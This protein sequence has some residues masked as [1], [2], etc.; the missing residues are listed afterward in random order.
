MCL[1]EDVV[2]D[3]GAKVLVAGGTAGVASLRKD[4]GLSHAG[5]SH[6]ELALAAP[7]LAR[8]EPNSG[9][10]GTSVRI[11]LRKDKKYCATTVR[12]E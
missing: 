11:Y 1:A 2:L 8:A 10:A 3:A 12:K 4:Q 5:H 7:V 9:A 6:L